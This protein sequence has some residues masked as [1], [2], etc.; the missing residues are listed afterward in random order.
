M[1]PAMAAWPS[2]C[3]ARCPHPKTPLPWSALIVDL[4][5]DQVEH[6]KKGGILFQPLVTIDVIVDAGEGALQV[7]ARGDAAGLAV[8]LVQVGR[9]LAVARQVIKVHVLGLKASTAGKLLFEDQFGAVGPQAVVTGGQRPHDL[10]QQIPARLWGQL[11]SGRRLD[12]ACPDNTRG[13]TFRL[14]SG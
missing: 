6:L 2:G 4:A 7:F 10:L 9:R 5:E 14:S 3:C 11:L 8:G 12:E 1:R 13:V